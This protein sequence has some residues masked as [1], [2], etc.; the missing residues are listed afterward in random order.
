MP[1]KSE[2]RRGI[3]IYLDTCIVSGLAKGDIPAA[4]LNAMEWILREHRVRNLRLSTSPV[5]RMELE[6]IPARFR[7]AH[8]AIYGLLDVVPAQ[9]SFGFWNNEKAI[10]DPYWWIYERLSWLLPDE[11]DVYHVLFAI[12]A[13][14]HHFVTTDSRTIL[15]HRKILLRDFDVRA[16]SPRVFVKYWKRS[17]SSRHPAPS[18]L[19]YDYPG[20]NSRE[21]R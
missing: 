10:E 15:K 16:M 20:L 5:T 3:S 4:D 6:K 19:L 7:I 12:K 17:M 1:R 13:G 21:D 9:L 18:G 11:I 2:S 8:S 14:I